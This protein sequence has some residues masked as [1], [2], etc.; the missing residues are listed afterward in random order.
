MTE[1]SEK[2]DEQVL[3]IGETMPMR[4]P[5]QHFIA[6]V[7]RSIT[8]VGMTIGIDLGD[9]WSHYCTLNEAKLNEWG[10]CDLAE[11]QSDASGESVGKNLSKTAGDTGRK[12]ERAVIDVG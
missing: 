10:W 9:V 4:K 5:A 11:S 8:K 7:P 6:E 3:R 2:W 1:V 12:D